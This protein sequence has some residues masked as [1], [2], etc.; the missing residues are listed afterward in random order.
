MTVPDYHLMDGS[1][2]SIAIRREL[3][4]LNGALDEDVVALLEGHRNA[5][6][7]AVER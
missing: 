5:R 2:R 4:L 6:K 7:I 3:T 1:L